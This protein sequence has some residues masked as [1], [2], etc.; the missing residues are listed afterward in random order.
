LLLQGFQHSATFVS[1]H[2]DGLNLLAGRTYQLQGCIEKLDDDLVTAL[3]VRQNKF[4]HQVSQAQLVGLGAMA[5]G[6]IGSFVNS[7]IWL[8]PV[9]K[10][11]F[12][13]LLVVHSSVGRE[14][15]V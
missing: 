10:S 1:N 12:W 5:T 11:P 6:G 14:P 3:Q 13:D 7:T 2:L 9:D 8:S 4:N 15:S